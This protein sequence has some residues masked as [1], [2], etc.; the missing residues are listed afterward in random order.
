MGFR[1][2]STF[3]DCSQLYGGGAKRTDIQQTDSDWHP[4]DVSNDLEYSKLTAFKKHVL[5]FR[6]EPL[7]LTNWIH[8]QV[9]HKK[10]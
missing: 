8:T 6:K 1:F 10:I 3:V 7:L 2:Q 5:D 4:P 9:F